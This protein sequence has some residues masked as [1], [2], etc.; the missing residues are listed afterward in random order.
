MHKKNT[1]AFDFDNVIHKYRKG[2][3]DGSV[4]DELDDNVISLINNLV[5]KGHNVFIMSTRDRRQI[6][7]CFDKFEI[8]HYSIDGD[9]DSMLL[10]M[11]NDKVPFKYETFC[12]EKWWKPWQFKKFWNKKGVVGICNHKAVFDVLVDDRALNFN[13][14]YGITLKRL[15]NFKPVNYKKDE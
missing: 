2:W 8:R 9:P 5:N 3:K 13:P 12:F 14:H 4:Y 6:K 15:I 7:K 11:T 1:V 10:A